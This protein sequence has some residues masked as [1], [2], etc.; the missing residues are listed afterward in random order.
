MM[1]RAVEEKKGASNNFY[2]DEDT[3]D[4]FFLN[5]FGVIPVCFLKALLNADLE[6]NPASSAIPKIFRCWFG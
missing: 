4:T 6:L 1:G 2:H 5:S 3:A